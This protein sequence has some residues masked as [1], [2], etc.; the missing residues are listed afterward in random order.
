MAVHIS[1]LG[2][3]SANSYL[4]CEDAAIIIDAGG[5][6]M[7]RSAPLSAEAVAARLV[8][9]GVAPDRVRLLVV[10]HGHQDHISSVRTIMQAT[11]AR[12]AL[13]RLDADRLLAGGPGIMPVAANL[14]GRLFMVLIRWNMR[15][16]PAA[17]MP[18]VDITVD[19]E[20]LSLV[21]YG[22]EGRVL[23]TP[24]HTAGSLSVLLDAG[25][26]FIGDLAASAPPLS[27]GPGLPALAEDLDG[28]RSS[29]RLLLREGA[30]VFYPG[31]GR[32]FLASA[33][34]RAL[35]G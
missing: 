28:V 18:T 25:E 15:R 26:A 27:L 31:H 34:S 24:G 2:A 7:V 12:L 1:T 32:P 19:D 20:G 11:G 17:D 9:A 33:L 21:P 5:T 14:A 10:T 4:F 8:A 23:H 6:S 3:L 29:L 22:V 30:Q 35:A 16:L 13:H